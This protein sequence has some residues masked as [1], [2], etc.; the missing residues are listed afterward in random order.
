MPAC[1]L[2]E[3]DSEHFGFPVARVLGSSLDR[4]VAGR[5]DEW[6]RSN[7]VRCIYLLADAEDADTS[8]VAAESA[9]RIVDGRVVVRRALEGLGEPHLSGVAG[10]E[11]REAVEADLGHLRE[12]ASVSHHGSRFFFDTGFPDARCAALYE[13][14]IDRGFVDPDRNLWV[15]TL[16]GVPA[17]YH[18]I[19]PAGP[20]GIRRLELLAV[21]PNRHGRGIGTALI[22]STMG[23][24]RSEGADETWT[25]LSP[26]NVPSIRLHERVGFLTESVQVWHHKWYDGG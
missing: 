20:D 23:A 16:E 21:D 7:Q 12:I 26:R 4:D 9:F 22:L 10:M 19:G 17:G 5:V 18:V 8:R 25:I 3:W 2:L 13:A 15:A 1:E 24:L 6:C 11:V 14:W